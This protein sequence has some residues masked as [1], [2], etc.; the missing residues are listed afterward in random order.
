MRWCILA[1]ILLCFLLAAKVSSCVCRFLLHMQRLLRSSWS[2]VLTSRLHCLEKCLCLP[3]LGVYS[4]RG[5]GCAL[6]VRS[7]GVEGMFLVRSG[8]FGMV[9]VA[10]WVERGMTWGL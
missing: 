5:V 6:G 4:S 7:Q 1:W 8:K 3:H 2:L 9:R 10:L